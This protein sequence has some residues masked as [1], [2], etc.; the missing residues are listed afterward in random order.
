MATP[1][2]TSPPL[3]S[4]FS[5]FSDTSASLLLLLLLLQSMESFLSKSEL[6]GL[7]P[8]YMESSSEVVASEALLLALPSFSDRS[9]IEA[10]AVGT[11]YVACF[12]KTGEEA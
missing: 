9:W 12:C 4:H 7:G 10:A 1:L 8:P 6:V 11:S 3:A 2:T 5:D